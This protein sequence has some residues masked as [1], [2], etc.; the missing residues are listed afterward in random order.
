M[1][2]YF[3]KNFD[4]SSDLDRKFNLG[5]VEY[6]KCKN[7]GFVLS[8]T[9]ADMDKQK[10]NKL[11][12]SFHKYIENQYK[13]RTSNQP[14]Y[15]YMACFIHI[16]ISKNI[17]LNNILD[18]GAG[19][20][21]FAKILYKYFGYHICL[22]DKYIRNNNDSN[23]IYLNENEIKKKKYNTVLCSAVF[24]H[25]TK[26]YHLDIINN[27]VKKNGNLLIHSV[28][29]ENIPKDP[30]WFYLLPV[31]TAFHTNNS[32]RFLM[33]QWRYKASIYCPTAKTWLLVSNVDNLKQ[34][35]AKINREL[36]QEYVIFKSG[37]V[38]YWK[39]F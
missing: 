31:H 11:N 24:E 14:P 22:Y 38:D 33:K 20:G 32:M 9:H 8:K 7:C 25:I 39:L 3:K 29:C 1:Y 19:Y 2:S 37:F 27:C 35:T 21:S 15:L 4:K 17:I 26:R 16:L 36:Q 18:Y 30:T 28:I 6:Y 34:K 10:W 13:K 12:Y 23:L 5:N